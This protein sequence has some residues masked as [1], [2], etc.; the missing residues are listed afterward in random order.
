MA[1]R[2]PPAVARVLERVTSTVRRHDLF[3][4]GDH[5]LVAVSGGPD[6]TC[7][8]HALYLLRRLLRIRLSVFHFDHR[9]RPDS[10]KDAAYA[11]RQADRMK[12]TFHLSVAED[13][14][15]RG[16]SVEAW[17]RAVRLGGLATALRDAP[18]TRAALGH[19]LDDQAE[20]VLLALSRGGGLSAVAGIRPVEGP[21]VRPLL[22][23]TRTE[24]EAFV[25]ALRLRPRSDPTNRDLRLPRN[26]IR[27]VVLPT[28]E[29]AVGR[30]VRGAL[31]RSAS[32]LRQDADLLSRQAEE[33]TRELLEEL[34]EGFELPAAGLAG[35]PGPLA[36]RVVRAGL[37]RA[38]AL[39]TQEHVEAILDLASGRPGR[40]R[41]LSE[42]LI[43]V[44]QKEYVRVARPSPGPAATRS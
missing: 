36:S 40:R 20:T 30:E 28:M 39:P 1:S 42:G 16:E 27:H 7:L 13:R 8:L 22:D 17:A 19:T 18:A 41:Q 32:L 31:A 3:V 29:R 12:L 9:L 24:V 25:R 37:L 23:V 43:A 33:A 35:L 44:R 38:G 2:R 15:D 21:L 11:R 14:P 26:A 4:A 6:S 10:A 5:V 34:P